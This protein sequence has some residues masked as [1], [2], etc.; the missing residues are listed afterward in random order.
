MLV[1]VIT[2]DELQLYFLDALGAT[3]LLVIT[4]V[5]WLL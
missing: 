3:N 1:D 4:E 2:S 5:S